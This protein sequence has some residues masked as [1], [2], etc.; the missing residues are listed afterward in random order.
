MLATYSFKPDHSDNDCILCFTAAAS[1][2]KADAFVAS[3][4]STRHCFVRLSHIAENS[5]LLPSVG[6]WVVSQFVWLIFLIALVSFAL[7]T[8]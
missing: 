3:S 5:P 8:T 4:T 6:V 2:K 7:P 1:T